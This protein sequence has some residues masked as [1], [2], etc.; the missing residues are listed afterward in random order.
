MFDKF[1]LKEALDMIDLSQVELYVAVAPGE[2]EHGYWWLNANPKIWSFSD[3]AVG[4]VQSYTLY[5]DNGSKRRIFQ[6]FLDAKA[7]DMIIG[8]ESNPVKQI[9]AIG[10]VSA[11]HDGEQ[12][13][14][15]KIEGLTSPLDY[16]TLKNFPELEKMEYFVN[17]QGSLFKLTKGEY[18][19]IYD[20]IREEN[21]LTSVE[22]A[23]KYTKEDF[24]NEVYMNEERYNMLV[25]VL[26]NKKN[27]I[28]QGTPGVGKTFA[29]K[30]LAYSIMGE[31]MRAELNLYSFIRIIHMRTS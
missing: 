12:I 8:Y 4:E 2:E 10:R 25:S 16:Q 28:L 31:R 27:I 24:L 14:F 7:G 19:F 21:P 11:E 6:N 3:I 26:K 29:A 1:R 17:P 30:R 9:V 20:M 15:E 18:D 22:E 13:Y 5:N 23:E